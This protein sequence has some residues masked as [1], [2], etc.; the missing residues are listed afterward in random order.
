MHAC[1][2]AHAI[3][4][5]SHVGRIRTF[6]FEFFFFFGKT[7]GHYSVNG[8]ACFFNTNDFLENKRRVRLVYIKPLVDNRRQYAMR[9]GIIVKIFENV[10]LGCGY[11]GYHFNVPVSP[12][13][14]LEVITIFEILTKNF[15]SSFHSPPIFQLT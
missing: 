2:N 8:E 14:K 15:T 9:Y 3:I 1:V 5:R 4:I 7:S 13:D 6:S 12:D 11:D 10:F